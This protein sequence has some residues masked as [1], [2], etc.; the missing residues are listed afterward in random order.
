MLATSSLFSKFLARINP[1]S[2]Q[3]PPLAAMLLIAVAI[4]A[5]VA[6]D[7]PLYV[8]AATIPGFTPS[9]ILYDGC[10]PLNPTTAILR[11]VS[12]LPVSAKL[13]TNAIAAAFAFS[14]L[15]V[16][17]RSTILFDKSSTITVAASSDSTTSSI[18][19]LVRTSRVIKNS[20]SFLPAAIVLSVNTQPSA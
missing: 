7:H 12:V 3:V 9:K 8:V 14:S 16:W 6:F 5:S 17:G 2:R 18:S 11:V 13:F 4:E 15:S 1:A 10:S 19:A 20:F